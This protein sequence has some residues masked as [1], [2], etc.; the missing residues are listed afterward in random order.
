MSGG[1]YARGTSFTL[2]SLTAPATPPR[3]LLQRWELGSVAGIPGFF[4]HFTVLLTELRKENGFG[5]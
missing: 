5:R 3:R 1:L 4:D 2:P